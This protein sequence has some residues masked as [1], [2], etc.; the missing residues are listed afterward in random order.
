MTRFLAFVLASLAFVAM[1]DDLTV[2]T[3]EEQPKHMMRAY[4]DGIAQGHFANRAARFETLSTPEAIAAYQAAMRDF[5]VTQLGGFPSRTPLNARTVGEGEIAGV[6]YEKII[7]ESMPGYPVP[8]LLFLPD[9]APPY[10]AVIVPCGHSENGKAEAGYQRACILLAKNGIA[11]FTYDPIG[12]GERYYF[13]NEDGTPEVGTT[14]HHTLMGV[15]AILTGTNIAMYRIYDGMRG[16]DY[17]VSRPEIDASRIGCTGNSGGGTLT[18]YIMAL[19]ERVAVAAPSCYLTSFPRLLDTIG[20]QD[21]E[22]NIFGQIAF[23]MDHADY[24]LM[25]APKPTLI[26]TATKDFFD[27]SGSWDT[28]RE[29]KRLYSTMGFAERVDLIEFGD[30]HG[31]SQPRREAMVRWM[32]RWLRGVDAP[33]TETEVEVLTDAEALCTPEGHVV[34]L[35]DTR[36]YFDIIAERAAGL[37]DARTALEP[38][39][40]RVKVRE[41][42]GARTHDA[43]PEPE[44]EERGEIVH[45]G[46]NVKRWGIHAE[47]GIVLPALDCAPASEPART[48]LY[49]GGEGKEAALKDGAIAAEGVR[50]VA[51]DLRGFGETQNDE[52]AKGW[53]FHAGPDW[54]DYFRAYLLGKSYVGMRVDDIVQCVRALGGPVAIHATGEA[55]VSALHAAALYPELIEAVVLEG[56]I[57]S[58]Q[59]VVET[60]RA[61]RQLTNAVHGALAVYDLPDLVKLA[62]ENKVTMK[63]ERVAAF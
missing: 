37:R 21:A 18:S 36:T 11:A 7:Y 44:M 38:D 33:I 15:P 60:P 45:E 58:W 25:R 32:C 63:E 47:P 30:G 28:F 26:C 46:M 27:I 54:N 5:F 3:P 17:L 52:S 61:R 4:L 29:A 41:I 8:G 48:V 43:L 57:P 35:P 20:P 62:G 22:Q 23:G 16:I 19:D 59:A 34:K 6:R 39:A 12:Q 2:M 1:G 49:L 13:L 40:L 53:D 14:M 55:T 56:G 31:F 9:A 51:V 50:V 42:I 24:V 10:P